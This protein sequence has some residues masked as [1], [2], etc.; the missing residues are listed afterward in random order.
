MTLG[1]DCFLV[2]SGGNDIH[3]AK[4]KGSEIIQE[5]PSTL[6][7]TWTCPIN[8]SHSSHL[9]SLEKGRPE[10]SEGPERV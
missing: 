8:R 7:G 10:A 4:L 2:V 9:R 1:P 3:L 5:A 6:C